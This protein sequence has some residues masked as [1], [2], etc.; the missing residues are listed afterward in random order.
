MS[1][2]EEIT[3]SWKQS[4]ILFVRADFLRFEELCPAVTTPFAGQANFYRMLICVDLD[5]ISTQSPSNRKMKAVGFSFFL[6]F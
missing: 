4:D 2:L 5:K 6:S 3:F 1:L